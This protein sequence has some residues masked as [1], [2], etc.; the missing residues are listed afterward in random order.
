MNIESVGSGGRWWG[1]TLYRQSPSP[2]PQHPC[3]VS[4]GGGRERGK[5]EVQYLFLL[6]SAPTLFRNTAARPLES[7]RQGLKCDKLGETS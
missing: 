7:N 1:G 2:P 4:Q 6:V 5:G 3:C